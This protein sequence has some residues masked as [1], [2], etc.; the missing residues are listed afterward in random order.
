MLDD[1]LIELRIKAIEGE[2]VHCEV[3]V[4]GP[5]LVAKCQLAWSGHRPAPLGERDVEHIE[6]GI[7][8]ELIF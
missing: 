1:G 8:T 4:G 6:F 7:G 3:I 5:C 2:Q